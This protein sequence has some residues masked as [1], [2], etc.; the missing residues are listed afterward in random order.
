MHLHFRYHWGESDKQQCANDTVQLSERA[1]FYFLFGTKLSSTVKTWDE[2]YIPYWN[3]TCPQPLI[4]W[5][6]LSN[7]PICNHHYPILV[8]FVIFQ[9]FAMIFSKCPFAKKESK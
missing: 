1:I 5:G 6:V 9:D 2:N 4:F 8:I 3:N 7:I